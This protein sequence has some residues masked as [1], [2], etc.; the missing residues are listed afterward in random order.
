M[1]KYILFLIQEKTTTFS[2]IK[3]WRNCTFLNCG[4]YLFAFLVLCDWLSE[5][6]GA[7]ETSVRFGCS[8]AEN[9]ARKARKPGSCGN[10]VMTAPEN[11]CFFVFL[12][13][14][15]SL[16][17]KCAGLYVRCSFPLMYNIYKKNSADEKFNP[18]YPYR[19]LSI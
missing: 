17:Y 16:L 4:K 10:C 5:V 1:Q 15:K 14:R 18:A 11:D 7:E 6:F 9:K 19:G 2:H 8:A 12:Q 3:I 13:W